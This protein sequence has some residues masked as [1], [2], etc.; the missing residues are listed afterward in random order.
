MRRTCLKFESPIQD[1][2]SRLRF[3]PKSNNLLISSWDSS[4]RLYDVDSLTLRVEARCEA[5]L[6]D[7]CFQDES[8][9]FTAGSDCCI[10]R[11]DLD[12]QIHDVI[13]NHDDVVSC[14]EYSDETRQLVSAGWDKK[15]IFWDARSTKCL[16]CLNTP[17]AEVESMALS[18]IKLMIA[19]GSSVELYDLRNFNKSVYVKGLC[20]GI[21]IRCVRPIFHSEGFVA[22][23]VDG[24]VAVEY[25]NSN[26]AGY[27]FWCHPKSKDGTHHVVPVNDIAFNPLIF[28]AFVTGNNM[29][30][31]A[32]WDAQTKRRLLQF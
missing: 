24:R 4:L 5:A 32:I 14:V 31:V 20:P 11:Y 3:A 25:L 8:I 28:N 2:V 29:G 23:S 1:A 30:Y 10:R 9:A 6:C 19:V 15:I 16:G 18:G 27:I 12:S 21:Q 22:G 7:C 13:G 26:D 17:G